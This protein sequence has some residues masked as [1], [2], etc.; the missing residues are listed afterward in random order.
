MQIKGRS[1]LGP[2][3]LASLRDRGGHDRLDSEG[4][5]VASPEARTSTGQHPSGAPESAFG[6]APDAREPTRP[7]VTRERRQAR[8]LSRFLPRIPE[9]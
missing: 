6:L 4:A 2:R 3:C 7:Y 9:S 8:P 1:P 5:S